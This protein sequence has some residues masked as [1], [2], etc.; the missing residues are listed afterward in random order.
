MIR[1]K[2]TGQNATKLSGIIKWGYR[3]V[4]Y[5]LKLPHFINYRSLDFR[6]SYGLLRCHPTIKFKLG[7]HYSSYPPLLTAQF[8]RISLGP[9]HCCA[10]RLGRSPPKAGAMLVLVIHYEHD[11]IRIPKSENNRGVQNVM[12]S[13]TTPPMKSPLIHVEVIESSIPFLKTPDVGD[14]NVRKPG[15]TSSTALSQ[16]SCTQH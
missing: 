1:A 16:V 9:T 2:T 7:R 8:L 6:L 12:R 5:G 14:R 11:A 10:T 13:K 4:L 3:S 15:A